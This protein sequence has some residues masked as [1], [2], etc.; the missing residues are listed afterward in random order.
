MKPNMTFEI[1]AFSTSIFI[2]EETLKPT[3]YFTPEEKEN[4]AAIHAE[5]IQQHARGG[6][7]P[8][9]Q[10]LLVEGTRHYGLPGTLMSKTSNYTTS[11]G[12]QI[13]VQT[14]FSPFEGQISDA[15]LEACRYLT[16]QGQKYI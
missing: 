6:L 9:R 3:E 15:Q 10:I 4:I 13:D 11:R 14:V 12:I 8:P 7:N 2:S 5:H 1:K 16:L